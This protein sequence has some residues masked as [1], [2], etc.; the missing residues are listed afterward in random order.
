[1]RSSSEVRIRQ[2][3]CDPFG[4]RRSDHLRS[5]LG[6]DQDQE[7]DD[8]GRGDQGPFVVAYQP[9][10]HRRDQGRRGRVYEVVAEQDGAEEAVRSRQERLH[11][12][13]GA[14]SL[15]N[16]VAQPKTAE[17]HHRRL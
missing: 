4:K 12:P 16:Q 8:A 6:E 1:V 17:R 2:R 11:T 15:S 5:D 9:N 3:Q 7:G 13:G 14:V 10:G